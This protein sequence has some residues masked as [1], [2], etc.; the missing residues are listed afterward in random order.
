MRIPAC[1]RVTHRLAVH[2]AEHGEQ[3][4]RQ[5]GRQPQLL[6]AP[7][8]QRHVGAGLQLR[9]ALALQRLRLDGHRGWRAALAHRAV[10][11]GES[12]R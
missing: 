9:V 3:L 6:R 1:A 5:L 2:L 12:R 8:G 10:Q 4:G 11:K 7:Q